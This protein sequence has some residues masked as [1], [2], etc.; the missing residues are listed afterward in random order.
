M[1]TG[2]GG[3]D[4]IDVMASRFEAQMVVVP[5]SMRAVGLT[6]ILFLRAHRKDAP[7]NPRTL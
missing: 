5:T 4:D 2:G 3:K 1:R 7:F 6:A